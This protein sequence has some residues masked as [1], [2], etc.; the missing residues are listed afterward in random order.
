STSS[1]SPGRSARWSASP[2]S[3]R[4]GASRSSRARA[5]SPLGSRSRR[6]RSETKEPAR[7]SRAGPVPNGPGGPAP[8][9]TGIALERFSRR[10]LPRTGELLE[11]LPILGRHV[12]GD[13]ER[14]VGTAVDRLLDAHALAAA[15]LFHHLALDGQVQAAD[16][17]AAAGEQDA[18][19]QLL[20]E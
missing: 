10:A 15:E 20:L 11:F 1:R 2:D 19:L 14:P 3:R 6:G 13:L 9:S 5:G 7:R 4:A 12:V 18:V 17:A 8:G 16:L